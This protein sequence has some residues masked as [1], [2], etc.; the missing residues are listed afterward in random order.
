MAL[1]S[2]SQ[3][4]GLSFWT[5]LLHLVS[6]KEREAFCGED[7]WKAGVYEPYKVGRPEVVY[8]QAWQFLS[9]HQDGVVKTINSHDCDPQA[10]IK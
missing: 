6:A 7:P 3:G 10:F 5:H 2:S 9:V 1:P 8:P 4:K